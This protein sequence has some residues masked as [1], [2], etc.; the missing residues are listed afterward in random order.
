MY[1]ILWYMDLPSLLM[2]L[3]LTIPM[4]FASGLFKDFFRAFPIAVSKK[5][6]Y[7]VREMKRSAL[8]V[9]MM[10]RLVMYAGVFSTFIA[11]VQILGGLDAPEQIGPHIAI[12]V[13]TIL[14]AVMI[15]MI[16]L[17]FHT[18]IKSRLLDKT[19]KDKTDKDK[20]DKDKKNNRE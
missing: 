5:K 20:K 2:I 14:Y 10:M 7:S 19:D 11:L 8:A 3:L 13:L 12:A 1:Y 9:Q 16:L 17:I 15:D 6:E 18:M 4:L